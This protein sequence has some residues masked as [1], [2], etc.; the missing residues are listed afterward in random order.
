MVAYGEN[1]NR[2]GITKNTDLEKDIALQF[3]NECKEAGKYLAMARLFERNGYP[4]LARVLEKI[5]L[6]E[7]GHGVR[8]A[9]LNGLISEDLVENL[10]EMVEG[11]K[12]SNVKKK[13]LAIKAKEFELDEAHD[14]LDEASRDE[15]RHCEA[16]KGIL[17]RYFDVDIE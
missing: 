4:E 1:K 13:E 2:I 5:G 10:K 6:E 8:F 17:K 14:V 9:E 11:E 3:E 16:L 12:R 7:L 15:Q